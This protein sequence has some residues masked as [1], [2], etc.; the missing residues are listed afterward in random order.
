MIFFIFIFHS[1]IYLFIHLLIRVYIIYLFIYLFLY[2]V[3]DF[4]SF[5]CRELLKNDLHIFSQVCQ[6][7]VETT[8]RGQR[9]QKG[10]VYTDDCKEGCENGR[11]EYCCDRDLCNFDDK[12]CP[13]N[14]STTPRPNETT[15][16][17]IGANRSSSTPAYS[18]TA[19]VTTVTGENSEE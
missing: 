4:Y 5:I 13:G 8:A 10:C 12:T 2:L 14:R 7:V 16:P 1:F 9:I 15:T 19:P 6:T 18:T 3:N 17:S 11:C